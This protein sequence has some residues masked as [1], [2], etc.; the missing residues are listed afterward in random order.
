M[1]ELV[2]TFGRDEVKNWFKDYELSDYLTPEEIEVIES[3]GVWSKDQLAERII[4]HFY[5]REVGQDST[6]A[7]ILYAKDLMK[8]LME[9]YTPLIYSASIKFDP[10]V[11]VNFTVTTDRDT[12]GT[13]TTN[14][15][16]SNSTSGLTVNSDT[17]QGQ[18]NKQEILSGKYASST[19][20]NEQGDNETGSS[21]SQ[22]SGTEHSVVTTLGNSGVSATAQAMVQQYRDIIRALNT[23]IIYNL[24]PLFMAIY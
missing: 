8:E 24:E 4:T 16:R 1:R 19:S 11:N 3:R 10:L 7:F 20:A 18:I 9:S 13:G 14:T 2:D 23:E 17:P 21:Q 22:D 12:S 6:G 5:L 15:S